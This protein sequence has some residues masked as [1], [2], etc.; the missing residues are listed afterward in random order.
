MELKHY[1]NM[2]DKMD[3]PTDM[4]ERL[5]KAILGKMDE[6]KNGNKKRYHAGIAVAAAF[7][8]MVFVTQFDTVAAAAERVIEYFRYSFVVEDKE[9]NAVKVDMEGNYL[10]LS[11]NASKDESYMDSITMAGKELGVKLLDTSESYQYDECVKYTPYLTEDNELYGVMLSDK[12]YSVGDLQNVELHQREE[13]G[14]LDWMEYTAGAKYQTPIS[15]QVTIRTDKDMT[16]EYDNNEIGYVSKCQNIDLTNPPAGISDS[17]IYDM[18]NLGV[19]AVL[20]SVQTD[21]PIAWNIEEGAITC[22]TA[23]FVYQ[24]VEYVYMGG[25][26][27]DTMKSFLDTLK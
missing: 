15:V 5:Q 6:R 17:E 18:S 11:S 16:G 8:V 12:L 10:T 1:Q 22:T 21:G 19:K 4:D 13:E 25:I 20:Y 24:G 23:I 3:M 26:D 9:G 27:H 7:A 2:Y 14:G